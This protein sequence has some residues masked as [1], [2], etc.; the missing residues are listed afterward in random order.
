MRCCSWFCEGRREEGGRGFRSQILSRRA[1][2][3]V[4]ACGGAWGLGVQ[5][6][7]AA[8]GA[9]CSI[10]RYWTSRARRFT[11]CWPEVLGGAGR[12][13]GEDA[14]FPCLGKVELGRAG[15]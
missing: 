11:G 10:K 3:S 9:E 13:P 15:G 4:R 12:S 6:G 14:P 7:E 5:S 2:D 1:V 8:A